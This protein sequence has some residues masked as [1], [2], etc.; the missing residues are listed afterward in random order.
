MRCFRL[1]IWYYLHSCCRRRKMWTSP[2]WTMEIRWQWMRNWRL[3]FG[4]CWRKR[5]PMDLSIPQTQTA[6]MKIK[7]ELTPWV[8]SLTP[9]M[10]NTVSMKRLRAQ[11]LK[12]VLMK[13]QKVSDSSMIIYYVYMPHFNPFTHENHFFSCLKFVRN[14]GL[15]LSMRKGKI[16]PVLNLPTDNGG[17]NE[18]GPNTS[19]YTAVLECSFFFVVEIMILTVLKVEDLPQR[20]LAFRWMRPLY[21]SLWT[22]ASGGLPPSMLLARGAL[23]GKFC[24][25]D[26]VE[27]KWKPFRM[28]WGYRTWFRFT[29]QNAWKDILYV[30]LWFAVCMM[31]FHYFHCRNSWW[32]VS[33]WGD[34]VSRMCEQSG[35]R[36]PL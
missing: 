31:V 27:R 26:L 4:R 7:R 1:F 15:F 9:H 28:S 19:L 29:H 21:R 6:R 25:T 33:F 36:F 2:N 3:K 30:L 18:M 32:L 8:K 5:I 13:C 22:M 20:S 17:E 10:T 12:G 11:L 24:T 23:L 16:C 34:Q 14:K 35:I